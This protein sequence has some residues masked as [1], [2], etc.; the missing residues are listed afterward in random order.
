MKGSTHF[1][2]VRYLFDVRVCESDARLDGKVAVVTGAN[3]GIGKETVVDF[4][5]RGKL[6][7]YFHV[8]YIEKYVSLKLLHLMLILF[9]PYSS[10]I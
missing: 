2:F 3:T 1:S 7:I 8:I 9:D 10:Y 5:R 6:N 4:L